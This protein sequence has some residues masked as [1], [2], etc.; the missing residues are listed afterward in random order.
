MKNKI[1]ASWGRFPYAKQNLH[2]VSWRGDIDSSLTVLLG[3]YESALPYGMGRSYGDS[4]LAA[5]N[6][7]FCLRG[8]NKFIDFNIETGT[9]TAES[10]VTLGEI[11]DVVIP[12]GWFLPVTPGTKFVTLGGAI[13]NDVHGKNHHVRGTFG[14]HVESFEL[15]RSNGERVI[16]RPSENSELFC[17]TIGGLGLTGLIV[18]AT[19]RLIPIKSSKIVQKSM[20]FESL[21]QFMELSEKNDPEHE[22]SVA[23]VDCLAKGASLGRGIYT[24]GNHS[25]EG[26]LN[27]SKK[28]K[29]NVPITPPISAVNKI[30]LKAFN[31]IY[32]AKHGMSD[33]RELIDYD[34]FFYPLDSIY[35]WNRI[36]GA[37]GFQQF[38]CVIPDLN[39]YDG[40]SELLNT[41]SQSGMGSFLAV[42]KRCGEQRSPGLISFPLSGISLALDFPQSNKLTDVLFPKLDS[43][44]R[45]AGGRLYPAK[46]AHMKKED[47]KSFY[48]NWDKLQ[49]IKDP[50]LTS[51]FWRRVVG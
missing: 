27:L 49:E 51:K 50:K 22:Y 39:A 17:G 6:N 10:G 46:D 38:Q 16:C 4:C 40:I 43:I 47:F 44:V 1:I 36:Y 23:W 2:N 5:S 15:A 30:T 35:N 41:I 9:I 14:Q 12:H 18:T 8:L 24:V 34:P 19:I 45:E 21:K 33:R 37:K 32:L 20:R 29:L 7:V 3:E 25:L 26:G 31:S 48:P 42:L 28:N 13:A 11:L